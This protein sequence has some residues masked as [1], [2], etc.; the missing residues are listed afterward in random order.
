MRGSVLRSSFIRIS[1][2]SSVFWMSDLTCSRS[3][4]KSLIP[5]LSLTSPRSRSSRCFVFWFSISNC[6]ILSVPFALGCSGFEVLQLGKATKVRPFQSETS[7]LE[8]LIYVSNKHRALTF[9]SLSFACWERACDI[10]FWIIFCFSSRNST[11]GSFTYLKGL[12]RYK[13]FK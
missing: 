11:R 13:T 10:K 4:R 7:N 3:F 1:I 12:K 5:M 6:S 8:S 2:R 9:G